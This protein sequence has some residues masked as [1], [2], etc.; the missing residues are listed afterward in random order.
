MP[1]RRRRTRVRIL[2]AFA[3][4]P[5]LCLSLDRPRGQS[6]Y[7]LTLTQHE[8]GERRYGDNDNPPHNEDQAERFFEQQLRDPDLC[9]AHERLV[10]DKERPEVLVVRREEAVDRDGAQGR[11]RERNHDLAKETEGGRAVD[12]R[13]VPHLTRDLKERLAEQERT[14]RRRHERDREALVG[15]EPTERSHRHVVRDDRGFPRDHERAQE[16]EEEQLPSAEDEEREGIRR[17]ACRYE[18]SDNDRARDDEA[19]QEVAADRYR[20]QD[21]LVVVQRR[22]EREHRRRERRDLRLAHERVRERQKERERDEDRDDRQQHVRA[23]SAQRQGPPLPLDRD[24]R[25]S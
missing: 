9:R 2:R 24:G 13:R 10:R 11:S 23:R 15:V 8:Q 3:W 19:V 17:E 16:H 21:L 6:S 1:R 5:P 22:M 18:L 7:E 12:P 25:G 4:F 20:R 14:E